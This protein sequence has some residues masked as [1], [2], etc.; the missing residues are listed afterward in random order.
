M[1]S[2]HVR[3]A[4]VLDILLGL[5]IVAA[6]LLLM[7]EEVSETGK[8]AAAVWAGIGG[9]LVITGI[10]LFLHQGWAR[11]FGILIALVYLALCVAFFA[12]RGL[13]LESGRGAF[14]VAGV[15]A[16]GLAQAFVLLT[17]AFGWKAAR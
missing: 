15:V 16:T 4:G 10:G 12:T 3:L 17:L 1:K 2:W 11:V 9:V 13:D 6:N 8:T 5:V 7:S 14:V